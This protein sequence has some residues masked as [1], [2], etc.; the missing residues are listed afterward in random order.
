ME[1]A[2]PLGLPHAKPT[3]QFHSLPIKSPADSPHNHAA[4]KTPSGFTTL[5]PQPCW[6]SIDHV[7]APLDDFS[8]VA[9]SFNLGVG[10][11]K[12]VPIV[13]PIFS[14]FLNL[15]KSVSLRGSLPASPTSCDN[16]AQSLA[17]WWMAPSPTSTDTAADQ[18]I[19]AEL[20]EE[21]LAL[22]GRLKTLDFVNN[23]F[24]TKNSELTAACKIVGDRYADVIRVKESL[25]QDVRDL[26]NELVD[27][28]DK[29][30]NLEQEVDDLRQELTN[31]NQ[32]KDKAQN[33]TALNDQAFFKQM[34]ELTS[35]ELET[36][37][38]EIRELR[39]MAPGGGT[40]AECLRVELNKAEQREKE[41]R[42]S[43]AQ[44]N[45]LNS[46]FAVRHT[47]DQEGMRGLRNTIQAMKKRCGC[48]TTPEDLEKKVE[49]EDKYARLTDPKKAVDPWYTYGNSP[50]GL[51]T[52]TRP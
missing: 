30:S 35:Q 36:A 28:K 15:P 39:E 11:I 25:E 1:P 31:A 27:T 2:P 18:R 13:G 37:E 22:R 23:D 24:Q 17:S 46:Q 33:Q 4:P 34:Y 7:I 50:L 48:N 42:A 10:L 38:E 12:M 5:L 9:T 40:E 44:Y 45:E 8:L 47:K 41:Q 16:S 19:I 20:R 3:N 43:V 51:T 14:T 21:N 26:R 49:R 6:E 52:P 32:T 29:K